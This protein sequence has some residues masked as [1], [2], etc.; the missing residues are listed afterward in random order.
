MF[1]DIN[2][3]NRKL[4]YFNSSIFRE[5]KPVEYKMT[6]KKTLRKLVAADAQMEL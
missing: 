1:I 5:Q 6:C 4:Y 2:F 3:F